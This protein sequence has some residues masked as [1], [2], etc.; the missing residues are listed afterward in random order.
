MEAGKDEDIVAQRAGGEQAAQTGAP[1]G[2][3][4]AEIGEQG[5]TPSPEEAVA[6]QGQKQEMTDAAPEGEVRT[7]AAQEGKEEALV[8]ETS[9]PSPGAAEDP[10][11]LPADVAALLNLPGMVE[12]L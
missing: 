10:A 5:V 11:A 6:P 3:V 12:T 7:E 9:G 4:V 2:E 1:H 8:G